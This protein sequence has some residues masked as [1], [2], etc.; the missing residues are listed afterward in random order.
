MAR[1]AAGCI[2]WVSFRAARQ[3]ERWAGDASA[4]HSSDPPVKS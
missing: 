3:N 4:S 2:A 1:T